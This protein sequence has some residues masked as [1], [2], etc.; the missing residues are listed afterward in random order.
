MWLAS[1]KANRGDCTICQKRTVFVRYHP[2]LRDNYR[3][4]RCWSIPRQRALVHIIQQEFPEIGRLKVHESSPGGVSSEWV[5]QNSGDYIPS[6]FYPDVPT[7]TYKGPFRCENLEQLTFESN[8]VDLT[9]TQDVM[10][11]VLDPAKAF[12]EIART[13]KPGGA[14]VFTVPI[15]SGK[16]TL[17]RAQHGVNGIEY[18]EEP[19]YHGNP[20]DENG[21]LVAREWGDDIVAFIENQSQLPTKRYTFNDSKLGLEAEHLDVLVSR[22][23]ESR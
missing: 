17:V 18:L 4:I 12:K 21:S 16:Q 10:E 1:G 6:H 15:Y 13:L 23:P 9:I 22:K 8:S 2:W 5:A 7:G 3:C 11:H 19:D 20:I 14:H